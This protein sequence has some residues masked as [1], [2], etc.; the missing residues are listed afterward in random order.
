MGLAPAAPG[1]KAWRYLALRHAAAAA[2]T[3]CLLVVLVLAVSF[4]EGT[5]ALG[6]DAGGAEAALWLSVLAAVQVGWQLVPV[7]SLL[8]LVVASA[9]LAR[10]GELLGLVALGTSPARLAAP[11]VTVT[12]VTAGLA[13]VCAERALPPLARLEAQLRAHVT[14]RLDAR[15]RAFGEAQHWFRHAGALVYLPRGG[16]DA[17]NSFANPTVYVRRGGQLQAVYGADAL[18]A[19]GGD[20]PCTL[21][22]AAFSGPHPPADAPK[23]AERNGL[24][25]PTE[26]KGPAAAG[27]AGGWR[28]Q[29]A[30]GYR[31]R[32]SAELAVPELSGLPRQLGQTHGPP[33]ERDGTELRALIARREAAGL[34]SRGYRL[35]VQNRTAQPLLGVVW[36]V[37][38]LPAALRPARRRSLVAELG[39]AAAL[40]GVSLALGQ[41]G[42]L[43]VHASMLPAAVGCWLAP[44][45]VAAAVPWAWRWGRR[46]A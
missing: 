23:A 21:P 7:A 17:E 16:H 10:S 31:A 8:G 24:P 26:V 38:A 22:P 37:L 1:V 11:F 13:V 2:T 27:A 32:P 44:A 28:L 35:E 39:A 14:H 25:V 45:A 15:T 6:R 42:R 29:R 46:S 18:V 3:W 40:V 36:V 34:A 5:G 19:S 4:V 12:F 43:L 20:G 9:Q 33:Q 41:I 30:V